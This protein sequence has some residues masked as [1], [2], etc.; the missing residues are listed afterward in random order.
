MVR[1]A[2]SAAMSASRMRDYSGSFVGQLRLRQVDGVGVLVLAL[3]DDGLSFAER[4]N[5]VG[6]RGDCRLRAADGV[7][8][9]VEADGIRNGDG[10][11]DGGASAGGN[12]F[13]VS[14]AGRKLF[15]ADGH[16]EG[17]RRSEPAY[18]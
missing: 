8:G 2:A 15:R 16:V 4:G 1:L 11:G 12:T 7:D 13:V 18:T 17:F 5:G 10:R 6:Q 3:A 14:S 9:R